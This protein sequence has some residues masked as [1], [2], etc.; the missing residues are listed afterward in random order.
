MEERTRVETVRQAL[1][2]TLAEL[3]EAVLR[4]VEE[5]TKGDAAGVLAGEQGLREIAMKLTRDGVAAA[6]EQSD[7]VLRDRLRAR[8]HWTR[9][10]EAC[11]GRLKSHG[12]KWTV[13]LTLFGKL[14]VKQWTATCK[15]CGRLLGTVD[16]LLHVVADMTPACANAVALAGA[17]LPYEQSRKSL[18]ASAGLR[19]DDN[20][21]KNLADA[22]GPRAR[23]CFQEAA[24]PSRRTV[25]PK[26]TS[27]TFCSM[28]AAS[29]SAPTVGS[30]VSRVWR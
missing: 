4:F 10:G 8:G 21:V 5:G 30:G 14:R 27:S 19:V 15:R 9:D 13:V 12:R 24:K 6:I 26:G 23:A 29:A 3:A 17:T 7:P 16:E 25:P 20:R 22:L 18:L 28:G 1:D 11:C 2:G